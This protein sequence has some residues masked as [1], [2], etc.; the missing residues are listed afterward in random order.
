LMTQPTKPIDWRGYDLLPTCLKF[1]DDA[2]WH[3][4]QPGVYESTE[5]L[6]A[7]WD[8]GKE[9]AG[10][11]LEGW[12]KQKYT[13][14]Q[15]LIL[16][17]GISVSW[18]YKDKLKARALEA[19]EHPEDGSTLSPGYLETLI[20]SFAF[21]LLGTPGR[22][23]EALVQHW[24]WCLTSAACRHLGHTGSV[25]RNRTTGQLAHESAIEALVDTMTGHN[26]AFELLAAHGE[27]ETVM[28]AMVIDEAVEAAGVLAQSDREGWER[29]SDKARDLVV[30]GCYSCL[31]AALRSPGSNSIEAPYWCFRW[32]S[33]A[34]MWC[35]LSATW[36]KVR[37][38]DGTIYCP[39]RQRTVP[40][41]RDLALSI[42]AGNITEA[43]DIL[44]K[45]LSLLR[46]R[47]T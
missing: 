44:N 8:L 38:R 34:S 40:E 4:Y 30:L 3:L 19:M 9:M 7:A 41:Y 32:N 26:N 1:W 25:I 13:L 11:A 23:S 37:E 27:V 43:F 5:H 2:P 45:C 22:W 42:R 16:S 39:I 12:V 20:D 29:D 6:K 10:P 33:Y 14:E 21:H 47:I 17:S 46:V 28:E 31:E 35:T 15:Q 18:K 24:S 36:D